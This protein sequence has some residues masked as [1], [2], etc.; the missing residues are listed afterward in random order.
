MQIIKQGDVFQWLDNVIDEDAGRFFVVV[1]ASSSD[2]SR[3]PFAIIQDDRGK[4]T[5][6]TTKTISLCA[7]RVV[8]A[9]W[10]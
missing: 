8:E 9:P 1:Y 4:T 6:W 3:L 7:R 5:D 2:D 10:E